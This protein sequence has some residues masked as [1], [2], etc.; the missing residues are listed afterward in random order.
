MERLM[1]K[2]VCVGI[3]CFKIPLAVFLI[4]LYS[5]CVRTYVHVCVCVYFYAGH[6]QNLD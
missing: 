5:A 3:K 4:F 1:F 6:Y 2:V